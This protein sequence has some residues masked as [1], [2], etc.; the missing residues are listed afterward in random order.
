MVNGSTATAGLAGRCHLN[1]VSAP[2]L[3]LKVRRDVVGHISATA[4][5]WVEGLYT[6]QN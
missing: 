1:V 5:P 3:E 2:T 6:N 4:Y